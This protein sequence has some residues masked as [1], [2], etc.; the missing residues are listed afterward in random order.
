MRIPRGLMPLWG[1][2]PGMGCHHLNGGRGTFGQVL[3]GPRGP[4]GWG[5]QGCPP[6]RG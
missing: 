2:F 5:P 4:E 1:I 6:G 3:Q